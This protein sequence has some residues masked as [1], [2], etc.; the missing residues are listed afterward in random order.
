MNVD[1]GMSGSAI[2]RRLVCTTERDR[3]R[4]GSSPD[5]W[6]SAR[7]RAVAEE[8]LLDPD[9]RLFVEWEPASQPESSHSDTGCEWLRVFA[10]RAKRRRNQRRRRDDDDDDD[11]TADDD[12]C[13]G[14]N[15]TFVLIED[16]LVWHRNGTPVLVGIRL[17]IWFVVLFFIG[18]TVYTDVPT[19][20]QYARNR[21]Q[22]VCSSHWQGAADV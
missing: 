15:F 8:R 11:D 1:F 13:L 10:K 5:I 3:R 17:Y 12:E 18:E 16:R 14:G 4:I 20:C 2:G 19:A 6:I 9:Q 22:A 7:V 21:C